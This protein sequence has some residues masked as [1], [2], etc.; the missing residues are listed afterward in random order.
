VVINLPKLNK[1]L[2]VIE[3]DRD[4]IG[5]CVRLAYYP[6]V[7]DHAR[8]AHIWD[9]DGNDYI[10]FLTGAATL[11]VGHCHPKVVAAVKEQVE[12]LIHYAMVYEYS[13]LPVQLAERLNQLA[14]GS[15]K[16]K[17]VYGLSGSGA[18]DIAMKLARSATSRI[19][20]VGFLQG[21]HG[22]TYGALS[23][24]AVSHGMRRKLGP[25]VPEVYHIPYA[26]CY[27][28]PFGQNYPDCGLTCLEYA[29][30][31]FENYIP[32]DEV[33]AIIPEPIQ[34]DSGIVIPPEEW[35]RALKELCDENGILFASEEVQCGFGRTSRWFGIQHFGVDPDMIIFGKAV[36]AGV[37]LSGVIARADVADAAESPACFL[38]T[39]ANPLSCAAALAVLDI[40]EEEKL[41]DRAAKI[42]QYTMKRF[43]EM[44]ETHP[45][46]G[47]VR[48][49]GLLIGVDLVIDYKT[50]TPARL[51]TRKVCWRCGELGLLLTTLGKS[52]LR[53][54]PP[55]NIPQEDL[56]AALNIIDQALTDVEKGKVSDDAVTT[57]SPW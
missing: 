44:Q 28:C 54:A 1:A 11:T 12:Q 35:I 22:S 4:A 55:L 46:I 50:K 56:D 42:G 39:K 53:V 7:A 3:R 9:I 10:D 45:L 27:R 49:K 24:T 6:V 34:G 21:Y 13:E 26:N 31:M 23:L 14:P 15:F 18:N 37:P 33:A 47:D 32:L 2:R 8:G 20:L 41:L 48:G 43:A 30:F 52:V 29:K 16:K 19:K 17:T 5:R 25:L 40:I 51:E 57:M 38:T 36:S